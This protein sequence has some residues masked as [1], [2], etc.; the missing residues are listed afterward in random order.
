MWRVTE[1]FFDT[2]DDNHR[3]EVGDKYPRDGYTPSEKR[4]EE[5]AGVK[6][7]R[8][9]ALI[10]KDKKA[11]PEKSAETPE[12]PAKPEEPTKKSKKKKD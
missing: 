3:Y 8:H 9:T 12:E 4:I 1:G 10:V 2:Q 7:R 5:L 6:N 11:E